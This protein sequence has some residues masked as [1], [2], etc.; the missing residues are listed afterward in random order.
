MSPPDIARATGHTLEAVDNYLKDIPKRKS[1]NHY[2]GLLIN[3]QGL[4]QTYVAWGQFEPAE[5][6][7]LLAL[8]AAQKINRKRRS[9]ALWLELGELFDRVLVMQRGRVTE[10]GGFADL[11]G[12]NGVL[13]DLLSK[14]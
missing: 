2:E 10:H 1:G 8:E 14:N 6:Y 11:K 3:Y 5:S 9:G 12:N 4:A 7:Y 13:H